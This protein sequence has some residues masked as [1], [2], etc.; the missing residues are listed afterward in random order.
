MREFIRTHLNQIEWGLGVAAVVLPVVAW[1]SK[2]D[3][4][5][6][7]LYDIFPPLGLIAFGIMWTHFV[8]G[9]LRRYAG[10]ETRKRNLYMPVSMGLVLALIL[11]HP[12]LLWIALFMDGYG[13]PP[14]SHMEAYSSQLLFVALGT[15]GLMIFLAFE[16]KRW[17]GQKKWWKVIEKIQV[18]G[19]GAIF[20]HALGLGNELKLDW[21]MAVWTFYGLTFVL[22]VAYSWWTDYKTKEAS[23][24]K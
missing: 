15:I 4:S 18:V 16:L 10:I 3:L 14:Q 20:I 7:T 8:V 13:L 21:F 12:G 17:F 6:A 24:A 9:A 2:N 23:H 22:S 19:M 11:L 5:D 1:L